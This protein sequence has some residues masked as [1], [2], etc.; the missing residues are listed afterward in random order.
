MRPAASAA[1]CRQTTPRMR[2]GCWPACS[3]C[4]ARVSGG[5]AC[6]CCCAGPCFP[7]VQWGRTC[8][9]ATCLALLSALPRPLTL[10]YTAAGRVREA[11]ELC[12]AVGQPWRSA[13]LG[14]GGACGPL[15]L[16]AAAEEADGLDPAGEQAGDLAAEVEGGAGLGRALW[17]WACYQAAERAGAAAEAS[18]GGAH[19]AAVYGALACHVARVLPAC[20]SWEDAAW[21]YLRCWLEAAVDS[22]LAQQAAAE[23]TPAAVADGLLAA[24]ALAAAAGDG[25][26]GAGGTVQEGL[27]VV[28]GGW[29]IARWAQGPW[30]RA[31]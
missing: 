30:A 8:W 7:A 10:L 18:G 12:E 6:S 26:D 5:L 9:P 16:G 22:A 28:R 4:C 20:A 1:R 11:R 15:P 19:E 23:G 24:D 3:A 14:G 29:P 31:A 21:A 17:R 13:S 27:A 2:S 25:G